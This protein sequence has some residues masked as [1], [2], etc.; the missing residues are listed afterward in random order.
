MYSWRQ[1]RQALGRNSGQSRSLF[2]AM[3]VRRHCPVG[4]PA[5]N[6]TAPASRDPRRPYCL[7]ACAGRESFPWHKAALDR[8]DDGLGDFV[9]HCEYV[10][11]VAVVMF[12]PDMATGGCI[13]ELHRDAYAIAALAHAAFD[14]IADAE[15]FG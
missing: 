5:S 11:K 2:P 3:L 1:G 15:L 6:A 14:H 9:L 8:C 4:S 10:D 13:I 7:A 12:R